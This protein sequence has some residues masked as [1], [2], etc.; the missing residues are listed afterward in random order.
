MDPLVWFLVKPRLSV[1]KKLNALNAEL[2]PSRHLLAFVGGRHI[3]HVS[4]I[5]VNIYAVQKDTQ[6]FLMSE[7]IH[8]IR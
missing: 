1:K 4:R 5:R 3:V 2:N 7:F 8:H 6:S